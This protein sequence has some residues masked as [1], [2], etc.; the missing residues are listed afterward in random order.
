VALANKESLVVAGEILT[1]KRKGK[2]L[3][4]PAVDSEHSAIFQ[5]L[6]TCGKEYARG[7]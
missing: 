1:G 2:A 3:I 6:E 5:A 4:I 7:S